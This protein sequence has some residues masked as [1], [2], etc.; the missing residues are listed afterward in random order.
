MMNRP[1]QV[2]KEL[3]AD[4]K[5]LE[6]LNRYFG[7]YSLVRFFLRRWFLSGKLVRLLD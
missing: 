2:S 6:K 5:N 7:N 3:E 4:L 1:Q